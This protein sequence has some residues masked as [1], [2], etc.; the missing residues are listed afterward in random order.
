L[1]NAI[2]KRIAEGDQI[3]KKIHGAVASAAER[4]DYC[5]KKSLAGMQILAGT[6]PRVW[7]FDWYA[8]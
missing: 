4:C 8:L 1:G 7:A 3:G 6:P 5:E 2:P